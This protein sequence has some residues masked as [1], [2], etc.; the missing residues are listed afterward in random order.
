MLRAAQFRLGTRERR[1]RFDQ[2][3]GRINR[4][5]DFAV[6]AVLVFAV[7][8]GAFAFDEAV[9][10]KHVLLGVE[11]LLDGAGFDQACLLQVEVDLPSQRVVFGRVGAVPVVKRNVKAVQIR[12]APG[13][14]IGHKL[15]RRDACFFSGNHDGRAVGVVCADKID[16]VPLHSLKPHPDI[17]LDVLHDVADVEIA[18]GIRQGG[19][20]EELA[21]GHMK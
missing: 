13:S 10:Q 18:I 7:A 20:D 3:G 2:I 21:L 15:L 16:L 6:V 17:G 19:G 4:A 12:L 14:N 8:F 11:E 1:E 9:G 5:A